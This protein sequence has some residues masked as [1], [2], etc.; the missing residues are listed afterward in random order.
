MAQNFDDEVLNSLLA[1]I[2]QIKLE[3]GGVLRY[4]K[5]QQEFMEQV[6]A[7]QETHHLTH[8]RC[9]EVLG[10]KPHVVGYLHLRYRQLFQR[11]TPLERDGS[12][13]FKPVEIKTSIEAG[14]ALFVFDW[15]QG[16][17]CQVSGVSNALQLIRGLQ[18]A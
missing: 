11:P 12:S 17:T 7:F 6:M 16:V 3:N 8:G 10:L 15:G 4:G 1:E 9:A 13:I 2:H 5:D 14:T 18:D